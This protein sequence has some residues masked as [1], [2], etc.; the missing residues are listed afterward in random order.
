MVCMCR[1][2]NWWQ[3][4]E[5]KEQPFDIIFDCAEGKIAFQKARK[6]KVLKGGRQGGRFVAVVLN[7]YAP[8]SLYFRFD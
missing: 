5:F 1:T 6:H 8:S 3:I 4:P 7:E 2:E